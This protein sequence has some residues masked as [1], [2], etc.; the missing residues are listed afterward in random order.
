[1]KTP[2]VTFT[3]LL[4]AQLNEFELLSYGDTL[5]RLHDEIRGV[6]DSKK[7]IMDDFKSKLTALNADRQ[8]LARAVADKQERRE[9]ECEETPDYKRGIV[10]IMRKDTGEVVR[11]RVLNDTERQQKFSIVRETGTDD[12]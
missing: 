11:E 8:R 9:V 10:T 7:E 2:K 12:K 3:E 1:M 6:E 5:A 4:P